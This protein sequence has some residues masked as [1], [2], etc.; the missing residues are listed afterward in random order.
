MQFKA[1]VYAALGS[2]LLSVPGTALGQGK[3]ESKFEAYLK[4][5]Q[6]TRMDLIELKTR[7]GI[8]ERLLTT[9]SFMIE[10]GMSIPSVNYSARDQ[11][12]QAS[13]TLGL[14]FEKLPLETIMNRLHRVRI[15]CNSVLA[16]L[17][18]DLQKDD[19][20]LRVYRVQNFEPKLFAQCDQFDCV[21]R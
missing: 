3:S 17:M 14:G 4:P 16:E 21:L 6:V 5:A 11:Q 15:L 7:I 13:T 2:T 10:T 18:P 9:D 1:V 20:V 8:L 19:F 12:M